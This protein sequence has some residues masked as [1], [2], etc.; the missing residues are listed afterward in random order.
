MATSPATP[1]TVPIWRAMFRIPLPVP[2]LAGVSEVLPE[3]S[4]EGIV[5]PTP[6]PPRS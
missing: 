1:S 4:S 2:N 5:S 6:A 3:P